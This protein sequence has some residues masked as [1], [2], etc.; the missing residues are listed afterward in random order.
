MKRNLLSA[1][2]FCI[3]SASSGIIGVLMLV[4]SFNINAG[5]PPGA[6]NDQLLVFAREN[7][8]SILWGAWLQAVGPVF[9][10]IFALALVYL[11]GATRRL[12]GWMTLFGA[13]T[14][15][16]VSMI[17]ITFTIVLCLKNPR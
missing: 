11:S 12:S 14:L 10:V 9:I 15:M 3:L 1:R 8:R 17:E 13:G 5:P 2:S 6:T 4:I 16:T 7:Y